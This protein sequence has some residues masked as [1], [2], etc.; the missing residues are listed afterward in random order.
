MTEQ[1]WRGDLDE[2]DRTLVALLTEHSRRSVAD[3]AGR[4][5]VSRASAYRRLRKLED[6][7]VITRY[8]VRTDPGALGLH[9]AA[10][11]LVTCDQ[12]HWRGA[13]RKLG[14]VPGVEYLAATTGSFDFVLRV[15]VPDAET[16]RDVVLERLHS[17]PE[18]RGT[19]TLFVLDEAERDIATAATGEPAAARGD[20][21]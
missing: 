5:H 12:G 4:A 18:V 1:R 17:I 16:L 10:L 11:I 15:R 9:V 13:R 14:D 3:L 8:T 2:V 21:P 19:Q 20:E 6:R 7:G